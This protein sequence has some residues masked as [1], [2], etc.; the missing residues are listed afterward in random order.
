MRHRNYRNCMYN[1]HYIY[2]MYNNKEYI[3]SENKF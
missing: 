3:I 2:N 1:I